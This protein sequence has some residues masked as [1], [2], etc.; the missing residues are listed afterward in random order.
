MEYVRNDTFEIELHNLNEVNEY[1]RIFKDEILRK[2][3]RYQ[4][5]IQDLR[6]QISSLKSKLEGG[7]SFGGD[8]KPN[9]ENDASKE[10]TKPFN[11]SRGVNNI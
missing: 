7:I 4:K 1:F 8:K 3:S 6:F 9:Y 5:E 10:K 2:E 11:Y